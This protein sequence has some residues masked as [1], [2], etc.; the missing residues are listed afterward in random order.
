MRPADVWHITY[1]VVFLVLN[2]ALALAPVRML[3]KRSRNHPLAIAGGVLLGASASFALGGYLVRP[4]AAVVA[5][6]EPRSA[7]VVHY[8]RRF[9]G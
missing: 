6:A 8:F 4:T 3:A 9:L 1:S 2:T 7:G 5:A